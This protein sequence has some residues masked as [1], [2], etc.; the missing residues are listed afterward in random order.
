LIKKYF[1]DYV[2]FIF[3]LKYFKEYYVNI[4]WKQIWATHFIIKRN[5]GL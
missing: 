5:Q 4:L 3:I 2:K 1:L